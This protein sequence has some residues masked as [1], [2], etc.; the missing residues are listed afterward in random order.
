MFIFLSDKIISLFALLI[1]SPLLLFIALFVYFDLGRPIIFKQK[2]VGL[3]GKVFEIYKFRSMK[4]S[5]STEVLQA[6][7]ENHRI[8]KFGNYLRLS[9]FDELPQLINILKG[10]LS[11]VGPR[12][13]EISQDRLFSRTIKNYNLRHKVMPGLTGL[14]QISGLSGPIKSQAQLIQRTEYDITWVNNKSIFLYFIIILRTFMVL[15]RAV[16]GLK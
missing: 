7:E 15:V 9:N 1:L 6:H 3:N 4:H 2:R 13:H 8:S 16:L 10:D 12:P 5:N 14:A 11:V